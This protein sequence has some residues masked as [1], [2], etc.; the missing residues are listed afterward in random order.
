MFEISQRIQLLD[1]RR[2]TVRYIGLIDDHQWVGIEFDNFEDG[3]HDGKGYFKLKHMTQSAS[4]LKLPIEVETFQSLDEA[5]QNKYFRKVDDVSFNIGNAQLKTVGWEK[6]QKQIEENLIVISLQECRINSLESNKVYKKILH[7]SLK[8]NLFNSLQDFPVRSFPNL[9][10]LDLSCN[11]IDNIE[12]PEL[13]LEEIILSDT[14][15]SFQEI[16]CIIEGQKSVSKLYISGNNIHNPSSSALIH[17]SA[18]IVELDISDNKIES[19][20]FIPRIYPSLKKLNAK[21]NAIRTIGTRLGIQDLNVSNNLIA[22]FDFCSLITPTRLK[23]S[24]NLLEVVNARY[25]II[26]LIPS[27]QY[28]NGSLITKDD[29]KESHLVFLKLFSDKIHKRYQELAQQYNFTEEATQSIGLKSNLIEVKFLYHSFEKSKR[30]SMK[31]NINML[32]NMVSRLF[33]LNFTPRLYADCQMKLEID[34]DLGVY[35][36][37]E[38]KLTIFVTQ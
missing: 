20:D 38:N 35:I 4:L 1:K 17:I 13:N 19:L 5:I 10:S 9:N 32:R 29:L 27:L 14:Q 33:N 11:R 7:L 21:G 2:G 16:V 36:F 30:V 34:Q 18:N 12:L 37:Q 28:Y 25:F 23:I 8:G 24:G 3:K 15:L 31:M 6:T 22:D 26:S